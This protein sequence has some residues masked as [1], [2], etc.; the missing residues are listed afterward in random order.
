MRLNALRAALDKR[1]HATILVLNAADLNVGAFDDFPSLTPFAQQAGAWVHVDGAFGLW[2]AASPLKRHLVAGIEQADSWATDAHKWLNTPQDCGL[3]IVRDAS[4]HRRAMT[5]S[6]S[7]I[8]TSGDARDQIDWNPEWTRRARGF[9]VYAALRE[10]GRDGVA[11]L[12]DRCCVHATRLTE[13][14]RDLPGV[15]L[16]SKPVLNQGLIR[17]L[18][19]R[20][21]ATE[22]DHDRRTEDVIATVNATGEA[23]FSGTTWN[24]RRAM[25]ISVCN[26]RTSADDVA[27][28]LKAVRAVLERESVSGRESFQAP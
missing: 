17:F 18:D 14:L 13:G 9:A 16:V 10:L 6:A 21:G 2:A 1:E 22:L 25:R 24:G 27:R 19:P 20:A 7:Y 23:F 3:A 15:E 28:T 11:A 8:T 12:V 5:H 26:W 4:A